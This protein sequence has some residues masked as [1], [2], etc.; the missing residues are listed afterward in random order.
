MKK[1]ALTCLPFLLLVLGG[2]G[3]RTNASSEP[4][5]PVETVREPLNMDAMETQ[6]WNESL[7]V[8]TLKGKLTTTKGAQPMLEGVILA[9]EIFAA[10]RQAAQKRIEGLKGKVVEVKGE[11]MRHHCGP[12]E[13]CLSQGYIDSMT[14]AD[15][16]NAPD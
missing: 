4:T 7:G 6:G 5:D 3:S 2:C 1:F 10:D 8:K 13:Q 12:L 11:V 15:Y 16:L 9:R 14:K